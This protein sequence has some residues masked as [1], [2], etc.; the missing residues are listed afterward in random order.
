[1][2]EQKKRFN[3][4]ILAHV[5]AGKTSITE[6]MLGKTGTVRSVGS[7][8]EGTATTDWMD[9]ERRRGISVS[10]ACAE[11]EFNS[12]RICIIDTP[13]H[14]DFAGEVE[15]S[16]SVLDGAVLVVTA[17]DGVQPYTEVLWK[18]AQD[19]GLPVIIAIN[20]VDRTGSSVSDVM[21]QLKELTGGR[22]IRI[23]SVEGE[24]TPECVTGPLAGDD[25][26]DMLLDL[27]A[28]DP[29]LEERLFSGETIED[30]EWIH[31]LAGACRDLRAVPVLCTS[32]KTG[33]GIE[34]LLDAIVTF[35]PDSSALETEGLSA[36][37]FRVIH[38]S[39]MGKIC[40][41]RLFGG[42]ISVRDAIMNSKGEEEKVTLLRRYT[43]N[44]YEDIRSFRAGEVA[45][46]CGLS[47]V[48]NGDHIGS[49]PRERKVDIA[50]AMLMLGVKPAQETD[51]QQLIAA[52]RELTEEEPLLALDYDTATREISIKITGIIQREVVE[53]LL[54]ER[55]GLSCE[56]TAPRVIYRETPAAKGVGKWAYVMPKP[57]WAI[58][59]LTV[60]PLPP[61]S[62]LVF[63]SAIK[64]DVLVRRYQHHVE[65]SV[66]ETAAQGLSGWQVTDALVTLTDGMSHNVHTHPLDFFVA[67]PVAFLRALQNSGTRLLE[68][69]IKASM[70]ASEDL[71]GKVLGHVVEMGGEFSS[72]EVR[73][74]RFFLE[75]VMPLAKSMDYSMRFRILT[76]GKGAYT[77]SFFEYRPCTE[78]VHETLPRKG[79]DPLDLDKW[80][81]YRR[82]AIADRKPD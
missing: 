77:S 50:E 48:S 21:G 27:A 13:G 82:S 2:T 46:V 75:A 60:E 9:I 67:T 31:T 34:A 43:G 58:V 47:G 8:D 1:M 35:L 40:F 22:A 3:I 30:D 42:E 69:Y 12:N 63:R 4:G 15:R 66:Y 72:P 55:Y 76:S 25:R 36:T 26:E 11:I 39:T 65:A 10:A 78:E 44:R 37:V 7:V 81:L 71:L 19:M 54:R 70:S 14:V 20:K 28:E 57:C 45:A 38:D 80:I 5:D 79:V 29:S 24:G 49:V 61:G 23:S 51:R 74:G 68:P 56:L 53:E 6:Q 73:D 62:G 16:L 33:Q 17:V 32:A 64:E 18:A 59:E 41:M 52:L